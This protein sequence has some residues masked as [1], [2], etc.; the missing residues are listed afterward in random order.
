MYLKLK[1]VFMPLFLMFFF[2]SSAFAYPKNQLN[3]ILEGIAKITPPA[4]NA[5]I[6]K[7]GQVIPE[8]YVGFIIE[9][10]DYNVKFKVGSYAIKVIHS[11][12]QIFLE[13]ETDVINVNSL[14][15]K[16]EVEA[17]NTKVEIKEGNSAAVLLKSNGSASPVVE[18]LSTKG[19]I[20]TI[21]SGTVVIISE[22]SKAAISQTD[23]EVDVKAVEGNVVVISDGKT[24]NLTKGVPF[25]TTV[26]TENAVEVTPEPPSP[27]RV[28][29][30]KF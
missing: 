21:T 12:A 8:I 30:S 28:E 7:K 14:S 27:E 25:K 22:N 16:V 6:L 15:G 23:K 10:I 29:T 9:D 11:K 4:G 17:G 13:K 24:T 3:I 18:V 2:L 1:Y 26:Q 20:N 5:T 19:E